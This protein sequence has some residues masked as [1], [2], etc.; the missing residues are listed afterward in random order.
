[1]HAKYL[2]ECLIVYFYYNSVSLIKEEAE[3]QTLPDCN[4]YYDATLSKTVWYW[5]KI[6]K[7]RSDTE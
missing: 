3:R 5:Q 2:E 6:C 7:N 4:N 1:M